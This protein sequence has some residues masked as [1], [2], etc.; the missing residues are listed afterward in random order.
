MR[1]LRVL[2]AAAVAVSL[3]L[4]TQAGHATESC[5]FRVAAIRAEIATKPDH[6]A[7]AS[8]LA[9][10]ERL[11]KRGEI[12]KATTMLSDIVARLRADG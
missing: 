10:A 7:L 1:T 4:A 2:A 9:A 5:R 8:E 12:G 11:C 3:G 6:A